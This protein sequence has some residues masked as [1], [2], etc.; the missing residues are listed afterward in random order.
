MKSKQQRARIIIIDQELSRNKY[1]KT[2]D[3][4]DKIATEA[5]PVRL[6]TIQKD[7]ELMKDGS[8]LGYN[9]PIKYDDHKKAYYYTNSDFTISKLGLLVDDMMA[10]L[11]YERTLEQYQGIRI[12]DGILKAVSKVI[13]NSDI[14]PKIKNI[15]ADRTI[16][17]LEKI[18]LIK[19]IEY[20]EPILNAIVDN[21][22]I[23]IYYKKFQDTEPTKRVLSPVLIKEDKNYWYVL[24]YTEGKNT[25]TTFALD[26]I[27]EFKCTGLHFSPCIFNFTNYFKYSFGIT[28]SE[29]KPILIKLSFTPHQG[30][31]L[32]ALPLHETQK[33]IR[34]TDKELT[35]SI[36]IKP[37]YEFYSK[38]LSYGADVR[39][40]S[41]VTVV[42]TIKAL[43]NS[44]IQQY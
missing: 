11:F 16:L 13:K 1:V 4:L 29:K 43:L 17:Q 24:G 40:I 42:K 32:K 37:S 27:S 3:L 31:Y 15:A 25:L 5:V 9:A 6:R 30:N 26:R 23:E 7:I 28:V 12:F 18:P 33:I 44:T 36:K 10:L 20:I 34:D 39:L 41:P 38:I 14:T 21:L 19:G 35:I 8:L 22:K 2:R